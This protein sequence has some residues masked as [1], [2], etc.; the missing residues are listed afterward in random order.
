MQTLLHSI[1]CLSP[2]QKHTQETVKEKDNV[3]GEGKDKYS[4]FETLK[5]QEYLPWTLKSLRSTSQSSY[6]FVM[7][8]PFLNI[9]PM[10]VAHTMACLFVISIWFRIPEIYAFNELQQEGL[11]AATLR[12][13][14]LTSVGS[15][16]SKG[17]AIC[18]PTT[19]T[20]KNHSQDYIQ[21]RDTVH[22]LC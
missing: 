9:E 5:K 22:Y 18:N 4:S 2:I 20:S 13:A 16:N 8:P 6:I 11:G 10:T 21:I 19:H 1:C 3:R 17:Q 12:Q 7:T 14:L 15:L